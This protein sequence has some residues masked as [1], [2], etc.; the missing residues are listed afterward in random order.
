M[1]PLRKIR[2]LAAI[3]PGEGGKFSSHFTTSF[4]YSNQVCPGNLASPACRAAYKEGELCRTPNSQGK[5]LLLALLELLLKIGS[6][7]N[8]LPTHLAIIPSLSLRSERRLFI[9]DI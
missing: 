7:G 5:G 8:F 2:T 3:L 4:D 6:A 1:P 9:I